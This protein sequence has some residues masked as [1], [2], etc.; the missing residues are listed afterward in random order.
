MASGTTR[1]VQFFVESDDEFLPLADMR[2]DWDA[3]HGPRE[4]DG[5]D[6]SQSC[7]GGNF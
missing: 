6:E 3:K 2:R 5:Q 4:W 1:T 7:D